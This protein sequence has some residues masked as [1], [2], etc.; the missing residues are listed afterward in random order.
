VRHYV[1]ASWFIERYMRHSTIAIE[2][3]VLENRELRTQRGRRQRAATEREHNHA[4]QKSI[5]FQ[6]QLNALILHQMAI[7][8]GAL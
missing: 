4:L 7:R 3:H 8:N 1:C 6:E 2:R 5:V